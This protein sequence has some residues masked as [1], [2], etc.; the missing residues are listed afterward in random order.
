VESLASVRY[1]D[2]VV[3]SEEEI[4]QAEKALRKKKAQQVIVPPNT[5]LGDLA[6]LV[7]NEKFSDV[8]FIVEG[9]KIYAHKF[10]LKF[11]SSH[12]ESML[13][14]G[15]K[16]ST[17][18]EITIPDFTYDVILDVMRFIYTGDLTI[19]V[20]RAAE[21]L[22]V[23]NYYKLERLKCMCEE[24]L[25]TIIDVENVSSLL[26]VADRFESSQLRSVC[27]EFIL[28]NYSFVSTT[29][30]FNELEKDLILKIT[31][32]A[33]SRIQEHSITTSSTK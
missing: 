31:K 25:R 5:V 4:K 24:V 28:D 12:F 14:S 18:S 20:E 29:K 22:E 3:P 17:A 8:I 1:G 11:R 33:I 13:N 30:S 7:N 6:N 9:K 15:M 27:Y 2:L 23:S 21:I 26:Q 10:L 32:E 19:S 16:E